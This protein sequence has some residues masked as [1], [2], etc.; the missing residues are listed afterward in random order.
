MR[1]DNTVRDLIRLLY[2]VAA[3]TSGFACALLCR[4]CM[5]LNL[6]AASL[7]MAAKGAPLGGVSM[8]VRDYLRCSALR[9]QLVDAEFRHL[10]V[11]CA[12]CAE[13][14]YSFVFTTL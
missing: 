5:F 3:L 7:S 14:A 10:L 4:T 13:C 2:D 11:D 8:H 12:G 9:N 6:E 1:S